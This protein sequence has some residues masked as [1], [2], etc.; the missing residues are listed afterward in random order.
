MRIILDL[1]VLYECF[2]PEIPNSIFKYVCYDQYIEFINIVS[3]VQ[4]SF[5]CFFYQKLGIYC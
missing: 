2:R 1:Y 5:R 3:G 4:I